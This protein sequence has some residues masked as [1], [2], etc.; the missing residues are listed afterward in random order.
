[1]LFV[2]TWKA[3]WV[4]FTL[5][6]VKS[7]LTHL[8]S[9]MSNQ[10]GIQSQKL[11]NRLITSSVVQRCFG[12]GQAVDSMVVPGYGLWEFRQPLKS[13]KLWFLSCQFNIISAG[14]PR[15]GQPLNVTL[16]WKEKYR[17]IIHWIHDTC[18]E[19]AQ[20]ASVRGYFWGAWLLG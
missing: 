14:P 9:R 18:I 20:R 6:V 1:M 13:L 11:S 5:L 10:R 2:L 12:D 7:K 3:R 8:Q 15:K 4:L 19:L 16:H 17:Q